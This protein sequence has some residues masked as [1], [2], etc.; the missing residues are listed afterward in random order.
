[1]TTG[2]GNRDGF[3]AGD[4]VGVGERSQNGSFLRGVFN[5]GRFNAQT[6]EL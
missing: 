6:L 2:I 1:M 5:F 4:G 3:L